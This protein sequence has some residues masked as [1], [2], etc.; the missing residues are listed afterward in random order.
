MKLSDR[1]KN[2][3]RVELTKLSAKFGKVPFVVWNDQ[4]MRAD[5]MAWRSE[6]ASKPRTADK[7]IVMLGTV[8][9]WSMTEGLITR[10]VATGIPMLYKPDRAAIIWTEADWTAIQP[11]CS[12][13]L[14]QALRFAG[15]TGF[16]L[17]DLVDVG[18]EHSA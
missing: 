6:L 2:N 7:A 14:W 12:T 13:E 11:H 15:L 3:Y 5:V 8:L 16:R 17:G 18:V 9:S 4:R 10:N 1:T